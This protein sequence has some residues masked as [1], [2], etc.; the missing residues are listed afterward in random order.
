MTRKVRSIWVLAALLVA[1]VALWLS[2]PW[3]A[4]AFL[5]RWLERQGFAQVTVRLDYPGLQSLGIPEFALTKQLDEDFSSGALSKE[6]HK[7]CSERIKELARLQKQIAR[8]APILEKL[9]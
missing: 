8:T 1:L 2:L 6:E 9:L 5:E 7:L 4:S 3:V